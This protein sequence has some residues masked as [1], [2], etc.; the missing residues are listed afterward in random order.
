MNY[1][2]EERLGPAE[3]PGQL[4]LSMVAY[5]QIVSELACDQVFVLNFQEFNS[6]VSKTFVKL[7][8]AFVRYIRPQPFSFED[9]LEL[10]HLVVCHPSNI[11]SQEFPNPPTFVLLSLSASTLLPTT[12]AV[13]KTLQLIAGQFAAATSAS[14]PLTVE[15]PATDLITSS[16]N[17][18]VALDT[19]LPP[20]SAS[21]AFDTRAAFPADFF[22]SGEN[23]PITSICLHVGAPELS[24]CLT[25]GVPSP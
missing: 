17:V 21:T 6:L 22:A 15:P 12:A 3:R 9:F 20:P 14:K 8:P 2:L 4:D 10:V 7:Y 5:L 19:R 13:F 1:N 11:L 24:A 16:Q 23:Y 18:S 25:S